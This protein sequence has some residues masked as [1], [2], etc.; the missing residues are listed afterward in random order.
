VTNMPH[1]IAG[2]VLSDEATEELTRITEAYCR[3]C[4]LPIIGIR[5]N[6]DLCNK[7]IDWWNALAP[8][9]TEGFTS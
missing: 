3:E 4:N 6:A 7:A 1:V 9:E 8:E 2:E 5:L